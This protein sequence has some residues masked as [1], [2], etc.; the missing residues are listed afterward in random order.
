M[1]IMRRRWRVW[2]AQVLKP[3]L[4]RPLLFSRDFHFSEK[5]EF[6]DVR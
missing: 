5:L 6:I 1:G 2:R 3:R 4:V